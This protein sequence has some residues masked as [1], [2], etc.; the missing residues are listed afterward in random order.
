MQQPAIA[1]RESEDVWRLLDDVLQGERLILAS[2]RG[3]MEHHVQPNGDLQA[4]RGSGG[5]VTALS[6]LTGQAEFTWIASAMGEGDRRVAAANQGRAVRSPL[7]GQRVSVRYVTTARRTYHKYYNIICNPLLWFLQH[8]MW[9]SPYTPRVDGVIYDAW[10]NGY[11]QVNREFADAIIEEAGG[12]ARPLVMLHDYHLYLAPGMVREALPQARVQLFLHI[13]W[14][15]SSYWELL[16]GV[17]RN[18]I[19]ASLCHADIVGFQSERDAR[20]FLD[21]CDTFLDGAEVDY[22][23]RTVRFGGRETLARAYPISINVDEVRRIA[24]SPRAAEYEQRLRERLG[25]QTIIRVD[26]AEPSKNIIRG[27]SAY[28]A[29]LERHPEFI[30]R[31]KFLAFLVPSRTHIRQYQ[32]YLDEVDQAV[33]RINR[34]FER[35][36]WEPITVFYEN[37]YIQAI[38]AMRLYDVLMVNSVIDGMNLVSKEGPVV[39]ERDGVLVLS[40]SAGAHQQLKVG[41]LP[42]A[43]A[44]VEGTARALHQAL[45][46]P[47]EE[48]AARNRAMVEV[49]SEQDITHWLRRQLEDVAALRP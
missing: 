27:F 3:P 17:M 46:M 38:A 10:E 14:P 49:I 9:S 26:R 36:G 23:A 30:G 11:A 8:Y 44:D 5:V 20:A 15:S 42:V 16:P 6:G 12:G 2:N 39:N 45:T 29:L 24:A 43:P 34:R 7:P 28:E 18:A 32:R 19:C 35:Q 21:S 1:S 13:P 22:N 37:N 40:E 47:A 41:S 31:V 25:E 48:R 33:Q 4:R